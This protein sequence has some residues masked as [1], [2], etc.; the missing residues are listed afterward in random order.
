M[1]V[2]IPDWFAQNVAWVFV[3]SG[4]VAVGTFFLGFWRKKIMA[5]RKA[6]TD[7][8]PWGERRRSEDSILLEFLSR[9]E[10]MFNRFIDAH[11]QNTAALTEMLTALN[12]HTKQMET[13]L[14]DCREGC[15]RMHERLDMILKAQH[16]AQG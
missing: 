2:T 14:G 13:K 3:G 11:V 9:Q 8:G 5:A 1:T 7:A 12:N 4:G 6:R 15:V 16:A 10:A